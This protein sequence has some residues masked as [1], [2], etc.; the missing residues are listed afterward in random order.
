AEHQPRG[1]EALEAMVS[2]GG[3]SPA[4]GAVLGA[5]L[6][7]RDGIEPWPAAWRDAAGY[8]VVPR[9]ALAGSLAARKSTSPS[10]PESNVPDHPRPARAARRPGIRHRPRRLAAS[11]LATGCCLDRTDRHHL[12]PRAAD[13]RDTAGG[14]TA[15]HRCQQRR[16]GTRPARRK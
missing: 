1:V 11:I 4:A 14:D 7:A 10:H 8:D 9:T 2:A 15:F 5:L 16:P 3:V 13:D 12:D 6:G